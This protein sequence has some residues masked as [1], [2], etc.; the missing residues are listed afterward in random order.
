MCKMVVCFDLDD[1]L[2]KEIDFVESGYRLIAESES[3][4]DLLPKMIGWLRNS[5]NVFFKFNKAIGKETSVSEYL[6]IYRYH[7]PKI[8]LSREVEDVL[9]ELKSRD[10]ILGMITDGRSETQ[11]NKIKAL[12]LEKWFDN[13]NIIIS[14]ESGSEKT[15]ERNFRY[16]MKN[17]PDS[18]YTYVGDNPKKDFFIPNLLKWNTIM[19]K[20]D[21]RNIHK[22]EIES[23]N[24]KPQTIIENFENLLGV[25][26]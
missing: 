7:K 26:E 5:E 21:G 19:L 22:Q 3:R 17:F 1:T 10:V 9:N 11:R 6:K 14:E 16:F 2:Y 12:G 13:D 8:S 15:D 24:C 20:D 23:E 4:P 18:I 25:I